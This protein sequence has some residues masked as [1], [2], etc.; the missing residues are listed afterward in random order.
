MKR[1]RVSTKRLVLVA[2]LIGLAALALMPML[3]TAAGPKAKQKVYNTAVAKLTISLTSK[4]IV[5]SPSA[6]TGG[7]HLLTIKNNTK[8]ARGVEIIGVDLESSPTVRYTTILKPGKSES[9]RWYFASGKTAYVRDI[10][11]C[12]HDQRSCMMVTFGGMTKA[13]HVK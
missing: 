1:F 13:I 4:G 3:A 7:N 5:A 8:Q 12:G 11:S 6:I 9:F 10:L 2:L